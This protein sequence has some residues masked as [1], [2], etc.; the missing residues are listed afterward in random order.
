METHTIECL[1]K[2]AM[3]FISLQKQITAKNL[4][5]NPLV[6]LLMGTSKNCILKLVQFF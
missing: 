1:I 5:S 6:Q 3:Q 2:I 4:R